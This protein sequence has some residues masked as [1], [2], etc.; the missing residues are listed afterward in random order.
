MSTT[1]R[2][3]GLSLLALVAC[4]GDP[5]PA[6][7]IT[8]FRTIAMRAT[9]VVQSDTCDVGLVPAADAR[10]GLPPKLGKTKCEIPGSYAHPG[11]EVQLELLW[12]DPKN[13][14]REWMWSTCVNPPS[15]SVFGCFQKLA[16]DIGKLP[17]DQRGQFFINNVRQRPGAIAKTFEGNELASD[18]AS[19]PRTLFRVKVPAD[20]L[21]SLPAE[22]RAGASVGVIFFA[23]P[24]K[25]QLDTAFG[26]GGLRNALPIQCIGADGKPL[27]SDQFTIGIKRLFLRAAEENTD[28]RIDAVLFDG[29]PWDPA[30]VK[31]VQ[32]VC[33]SGEA[34]F[35]RC[36]DPKH[37]ITL[38][39]AQPF[40]QSGKDELGATFEEQ[41]VI[42]YYVTEGLFEY[43]VKRAE[44]PKTRFAGRREKLGDQTMWIVIR[45]SRGGVSWVTRR[46]RVVPG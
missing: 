33:D 9:R 16:A 23:C 40:K 17:P 4:G 14:P 1:T 25:L 39:L 46:F 29:K 24:G 10:P 19:D 6:S 3:I 30:E 38:Q 5:D 18:P 15:T 11:D 12:H 28:P 31:D 41:V 45:D 13:A 32:A 27:G 36:G 43:D 7:R 8:S 20:A 22:A 26:S 42:Q 34:R 44:D 37:D 21:S 2:I 35:D